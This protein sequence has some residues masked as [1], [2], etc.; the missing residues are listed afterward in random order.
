MPPVLIYVNCVG[1]WLLGNSLINNNGY[2]IMH[3]VSLYII[4]RS[5][6]LYDM[7]QKFKLS[8]LLISYVCLFLLIG[9]IGYAHWSMIYSRNSI[10]MIIISIIMLLVFLK[11][12]MHYSLVNNIAKS[13]LAVYLIQEGL[14]GIVA[15]RSNCVVFYPYYV[16]MGQIAW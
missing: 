12:E 11:I 9:Y 4:A 15:Y 3:F 2:N 13:M 16:S 14:L 10:F 5:L 8:H 1:G 7:P 6:K